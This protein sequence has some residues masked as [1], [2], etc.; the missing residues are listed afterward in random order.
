[1][2]VVKK[3]IDM[4]ERV[5]AASFMG[6]TIPSEMLIASEGYGECK[7]YDLPDMQAHTVQG[8]P[9]GTT[10]LCPHPFK[11]NVFFAISNFVPVFQAQEAK[12]VRVE[13]D[14]SGEWTMHPIMDIPFLHRID[15]F[16]KDGRIY[17]VGAT[18]CGSKQDKDDWSDPGKVLVGEIDASSYELINLRPV[19][20]GLLRNHGFIRTSFKGQDAYLISGDTGV[21]VLPVPAEPSN[22]WAGEELF[23]FAVSDVAVC[24]ID[25]DG[26]QE[27][28]AILP[29]H[30]NRFVIFKQ[31]GSE[32]ESIYERKIEF[33]HVLW[34]GSLNGIKSFILGYRQSD[35]KLIV[36]RKGS[37]GFSEDLVDV[38]CGPSQIACAQGTGCFHILSANRKVGIVDG[39]VALYTLFEE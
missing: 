18:L 38:D 22:D 8:N 20:E 28:G 9:G 21:K 3:K 14:H 36:I 29:F 12:L 33:G 31:N 11:E 17:F 26:D 16:G 13:R 1:M 19:L 24:D 15:V 25:D 30:G 32:Y 5:Y 27:I 6:D 34:G 4:I 37:D 39:E 10:D 23:D 35:Q 2:K 7:V